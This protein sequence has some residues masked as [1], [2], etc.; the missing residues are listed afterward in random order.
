M[1]FYQRFVPGLAIYSY[2]VG[3][4]KTKQCAVIDATRDVDE[5]LAIARKEGLRITH[6]LE[7]HVHADFVSGSAELKDRVGGELEVV[8]S[9]LGGAE[10]TPPYADRVVGDGDE[11]GLGSVRLRA[12]HTPGHTYEHVAWLLFDDTRSSTT[13]WLIFS[14]DFLFVGDV[15]R[16]DLLGEQARERLAHQLYE[17]VFGVLPVLGRLRDSTRRVWPASVNSS[18][19]CGKRNAPT[20]WSPLPTPA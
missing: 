8:V 19:I 5:F 18:R 2:M 15:G 10:W 14:G 7:T 1:F 17:S 4:E 6:A 13:P 11:V 16:P 12:V 20:C 9:G 3:D